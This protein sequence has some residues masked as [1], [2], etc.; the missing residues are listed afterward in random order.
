MPSSIVKSFAK[1]SNTEIEKVEQLWK[2]SIFEILKSG[3]KETDEDFYP[4]VVNVLKK[5]LNLEDATINTTSLGNASTFGG[6]ANF[7]DKIGKL[8]K[9]KKRKII[10]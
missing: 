7:A 6:S 8:S 5:K 4:N 2:D 3:K 9:K 1:R 10:K